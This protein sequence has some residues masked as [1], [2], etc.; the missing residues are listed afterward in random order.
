MRTA[1]L[2]FLLVSN[3]CAQTRFPMRWVGEIGHL[4]TPANLGIATAHADKEFGTVRLEGRDAAGKRWRVWL[5]VSGG[6]GGTDVWTADFDRNG[7]TD[8]LIA[9]SFPGNGRCIQTAELYALMFEASGRPVPWRGTSSSM[10]GFRQPPVSI[11]DSDRDG[12][13]EMV[14]LNCEY[15]GPGAAKHSIGGVYAA[16]DAAWR[17]VRSTP[18]PAHLAAAR[19]PL[20]GSS[21]Q[22]AP[23][24][25]AS[26][27]DYLDGWGQQR[28]LLQLRSLSTGETGCGGI[29]LEVIEGQV[30]PARD[31]CESVKGTH[32]SDGSSSEEWPAVAIDSTGGR[33]VFL[34]AFDEALFSLLRLGDRF[35]KVGNIESPALLWADSSEGVSPADVIATFRTGKVT[36]SAQGK[37]AGRDAEFGTWFTMDGQACYYLDGAV[38]ARITEGCPA[39]ERLRR[40]GISGGAIRVRQSMA[41]QVIPEEN[42]I[43]TFRSN[44]G[45]ELD[46]TVF[47]PVPAQPIARVIGAVN[48]GGDYWL[49]EWQSAAR[50][51][52]ALHAPSGLPMTGALRNPLGQ[53][54][55]VES[56]DHQGVRFV[57]W[58][59]GMPVEVITAAA[60]IEWK[61][62]SQ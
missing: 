7:H 22:L 41:W 59:G 20:R 26:W 61:R 14:T 15:D 60:S 62:Q 9:S 11:V 29:R 56:S 35:R 3:L 12:R 54:R 48:F 57:R 49:V 52:L 10:T 33:D 51:W 50:H 25:P 53:A 46:S 17:P 1:R 44:D 24:S 2:A 28:P 23:A 47:Q 4:T 8:L 58:S 32:Y 27:P 37:P 42:R 30:V 38:V 55:L 39:I 34:T 6:V 40:A 19:W 31:E 21:I 36:R 13:A 45:G 43:R 5:E 16:R 18:F